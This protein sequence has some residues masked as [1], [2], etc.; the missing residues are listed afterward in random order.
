MKIVGKIL[1]RLQRSKNDSCEKA[2]LMRHP[3]HSVIWM[4]RNYDLWLLTYMQAALG[5]AV[6]V[7]ACRHSSPAT[8]GKQ[9]A[10][11]VAPFSLK[12][13]DANGITLLSRQRNRS[14]ASL[15]GL[16]EEPLAS[17]LSATLQGR[18]GA[19]R[20]QT[21]RCLRVRLTEN[22]ANLGRPL[23]RR[24]NTSQQSNSFWELKAAATILVLQ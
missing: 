2:L 13:K 18:Q 5:A 4:E 21:H 12:S 16:R 14:R 15:W 9:F 23:Q 8:C 22:G 11:I 10:N 7:R 6:R 19:K 1:R 3:G 17:S 24:A 20:P